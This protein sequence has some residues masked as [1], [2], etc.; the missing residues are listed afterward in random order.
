MVQLL[1]VARDLAVDRVFGV[2][3]LLPPDAEP[4]DGHGKSS[5]RGCKGE[6][7][8]DAGQAVDLRRRIGDLQ[9]EEP[10]RERDQEWTHRMFWLVGWFGISCLLGSGL[11]ERPPG[12]GRPFARCTACYC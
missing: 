5:Q 10:E 8:A 7:F 11:R 3:H 6:E 9:N 4:V 12:I 1:A 2:V